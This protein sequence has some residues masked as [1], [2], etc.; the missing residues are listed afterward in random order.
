MER[1]TVTFVRV[2]GKTSSEER[3]HHLIL[4]NIMK[5]FR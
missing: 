4:L 1:L 3:L 5:E 2:T